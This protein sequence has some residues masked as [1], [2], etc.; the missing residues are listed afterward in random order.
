MQQNNITYRH[1][2]MSGG[3]S[4]TET[5]KTTKGANKEQ[6]AHNFTRKGVVLND[7]E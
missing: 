5:T 3:D 7:T 1:V 6:T 4:H 2:H